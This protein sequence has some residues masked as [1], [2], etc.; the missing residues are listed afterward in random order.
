MGAV[1]DVSS[2]TRVGEAD[3][4][5]GDRNRAETNRHGLPDDRAKKIE[6]H[7]DTFWSLFLRKGFGKEYKKLGP[8]GKRCLIS[9][10]AYRL[11]GFCF[12]VFVF[13]R[14]P[15]RSFLFSFFSFITIG[16][17]DGCFGLSSLAG[18]PAAMGFLAIFPCTISGLYWCTRQLLDEDRGRGERWKRDDGLAVLRALGLDSGFIEDTPYCASPPFEYLDCIVFY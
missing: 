13:S 18:G 17:G 1:S 9:A 12:L 4:E 6:Y 8:D 2:A 15:L 11:W 10:I 14:P 16:Y 5:L 7:E 3:I